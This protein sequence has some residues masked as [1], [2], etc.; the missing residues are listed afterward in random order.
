MVPYQAQ[1]ALI[2][3]RTGILR[4]V[5][6][7]RT[8][9]APPAAWARWLPDSQHLVV[10][11]LDESYLVSAPAMAARPMFFLHGHDHNI[12]DSEDLNFSSVIVP[13]HR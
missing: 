5:H 9:M 1:L 12:Q 2:N 7:T 10:G 11:G 3:V 8:Q 13:P 6:G 4:L